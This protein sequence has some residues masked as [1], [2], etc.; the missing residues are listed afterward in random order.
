MWGRRVVLIVVAVLLLKAPGTL[1]ESL[2]MLTAWGCVPI[3]TAWG[4][5]RINRPWRS[6]NHDP[7]CKQCEYDL[8]GI[9][10]GVCPECGAVD[11]RRG[12]TI[13]RWS[14]ARAYAWLAVAILVTAGATY[15][16][17]TALAY[18]SMDEMWGCP[19]QTNEYRAMSEGRSA[20][21]M[22]AI[23]WGAFWIIAYAY[24]LIRTWLKSDDR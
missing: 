9:D 23:A 15:E 20:A 6:P 3:A 2:I 24:V 18:I 8:T 7:R 12:H 17:Y 22:A 11:S 4:L 5:V 16:T 19:E 21:A 13:R 14:T 1:T 10:T